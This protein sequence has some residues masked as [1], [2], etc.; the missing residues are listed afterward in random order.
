[1][2][3]APAR[4]PMGGSSLVAGATPAR[5]GGVPEIIATRKHARFSGWA[6]LEVWRVHE[7]WHPVVVTL[8]GAVLA[9][10]P[11]GSVRTVWVAVAC[12]CGW[13][14]GMYAGDVFGA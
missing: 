12:V 13:I 4:R 7:C 6:H 10:L 14:A 2:S 9:G 1:M 3:C 11:V 8:A 5:V